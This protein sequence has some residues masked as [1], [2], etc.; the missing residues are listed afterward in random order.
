MKDFSTYEADLAKLCTNRVMELHVLPTEKCNFRCVYCY[1]TFEKGR[2][3]QP[4]RTG[5]KKLIDRRSAALDVLS[6]AWFGGEPLVAS[7]IVLDISG[8]AKQ[9]IEVHGGQFLGSMTTNGWFLDS[10]MLARLN[11]V[12]VRTFQ[13]TL[14]GPK[15][16][17]NQTRIQGSGQGTFDRIWANLCAARDSDLDFSIMI[18]LHIRPS[19]TDTLLAWMPELKSALLSDPRFSLLVKPVEHLGGPNDAAID[20]FADDA[21]RHAAVA[22]FYDG[23]AE[24]SAYRTDI[25]GKACYA[26]RPNAWVIRSDGRLAR[27]TVALESGRNTVGQLTPQGA[28]EIDH[29]KLR[30]W[31]KGLSDLDEAVIGCPA[32]HL[33]SGGGG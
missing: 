24:K 13:I 16:L 12:G 9:A 4:I 30:P 15:E 2:M 14:D 22:R 19:N 6:I 31:F 28:L 18:R 26:C 17:H 25:L 5:L 20:V 23:L 3:P 11:A 8:H 32:Q 33:F 27:C 21:A 10:A 1:E 29:D 7:D